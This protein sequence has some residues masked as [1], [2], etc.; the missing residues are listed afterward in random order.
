MECERRID[1]LCLLNMSDEQPS[2]LEANGIFH[3]AVYGTSD[4]IEMEERRSTRD[5]QPSV[6]RDREGDLN[7]KKLALQNSRAGYIGNLTKVHNEIVHLTESGASPEDVSKE[8]ARFD[9]AWRKFVDAHKSYLKLLDPLMDALVLEKT[10]KTYDE[11]LQRKLNLDFSVRLWYKGRE[12]ERG[13]N[14]SEFSRG[15]Q[16]SRRSGISTSS[17]RLSTVSRK[18]EKLA[19]AQLNL[20]QLRIRQR[21]EQEMQEMREKRDQELQAMQE[22]QER[23]EHEIRRKRELVEAEMEAERAAVSLQ[24]YEEESVEQLQ[25]KSFLDYLVP[26]SR[27][28]GVPD[29]AS[30]VSVNDQLA[31]HSENATIVTS[32]L[33]NGTPALPRSTEQVDLIV[34][35]SVKPTVSIPALTMSLTN[36]LAGNVSTMPTPMVQKPQR[37]PLVS[38][39]SSLPLVDPVLPKIEPRQT[40]LGQRV[41]ETWSSSWQM[42]RPYVPQV[43]KAEPANEQFDSGQE[44]VKAL[45]Q[46]VSSPKVEYHRFDGDPLKYVTFMRNFETYLEKDNPDESRRLQLLIQHCTGKAREAIESCANLSNDGYRVA[47]QTLREN[48]GKPHVTAE[49]HVKKLLNLPCMKSVD[50]PSLLE[51]SRHLDTADRTLSGMGNEYV[52]DLNHMNTLR[53][54]AK[55][56]PM[57]LR[58]RW[59][60]CAGKIIGADRRPKFQD[61]V[62]FVKERA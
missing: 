30:K 28:N 26:S 39:R 54:L 49:A 45:R 47:K 24:V 25:E 52:S 32:A 36:P 60:E 22:K 33:S 31:V 59:T 27:K 44:M 19:L 12:P 53:E 13:D 8:C 46:V 61:F 41:T 62:A 11:Q 50:G 1:L 51:F 20:R 7:E 35:V 48:F 5:R 21:L 56:L 43:V 6:V 4:E 3:T 10:Q 38:S 17:S 57:F 16:R 9:R 29:N 34:P 40:S 37:T 55:K 58:G 42:P 23:E 18:R 14:Y 2:P 15:T